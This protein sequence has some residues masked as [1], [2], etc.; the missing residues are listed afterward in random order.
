MLDVFDVS[1]SRFVGIFE[2]T[3]KLPRQSPNECDLKL[4]LVPKWT[5]SR[6]HCLIGSRLTPD[7]TP[8]HTQPTSLEE[9]S[10][11]FLFCSLFRSCIFICSVDRLTNPT[12]VSSL[13]FL[14]LILVTFIFTFSYFYVI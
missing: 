7:P 12:F 4:N 13:P 5:A 10:F 3:Q 14:F 11:H 9:V 6:N 8:V 2:K 1:F